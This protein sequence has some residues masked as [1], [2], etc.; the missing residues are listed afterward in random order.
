MRRRLAELLSDVASRLLEMANR[1]D[2][3][4]VQLVEELA[5][6]AEPERPAPDPDLVA[7]APTREVAI[8]QAMRAAGPDGWLVLHRPGC[9]GGPGC[10]CTP[11][12]IRSQAGA[13]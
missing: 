3:E 6:L 8:G 5:D 2:P 4:T 1:L 10:S 12:A 13:A 9:P 11:H 7:V